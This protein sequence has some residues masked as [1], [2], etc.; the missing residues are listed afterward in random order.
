MSANNCQCARNI[1]FGIIDTSQ[2]AG[3]LPN[4][5]PQVMRTDRNARGAEKPAVS[6]KPCSCANTVRFKHKN[7]MI[8]AVEKTLFLSVTWFE[9]G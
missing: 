4:T 2:R 8:S 3:K 5:N 6:E 1:D 7:D 9:E